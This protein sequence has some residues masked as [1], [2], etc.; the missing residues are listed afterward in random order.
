MATVT[1]RVARKLKIEEVYVFCD[2]HVDGGY[3]QVR[4]TASMTQK[5][6]QGDRE[7]AN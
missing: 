4:M 1:K 7:T 5:G 3:F 2:G 6:A